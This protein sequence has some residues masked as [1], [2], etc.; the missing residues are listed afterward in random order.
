MI[1][2][3]R[4][5]IIFPLSPTVQELLLDAD[6]D[7]TRVTAHL[8][9]GELHVARMHG[10]PAGAVVIE[11]LTPDSWEIMNCAV[12]PEF[13]CRGLGTQLIRHALQTIMEKGAAYAV[14]GTSDASPA[15]M[16]LYLKCGFHVT[17]VIRNH[18]PDNY[19][20]PVLDNGVPCIDMI[21]M[22]A[23]LQQ[24][25]TQPGDQKE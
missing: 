19:P 9:R 13:R 23:N 15:P 25:L 17:G 14:L 16:A 24:A 3:E 8:E 20:A 5:P 22:R 12:A 2:I 10:R 18:F 4:E 21:R 7:I 6:P 11:P 1:H